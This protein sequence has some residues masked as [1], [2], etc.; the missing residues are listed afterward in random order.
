MASKNYTALY[1]HLVWCTKRR[2]PVLA[3]TWRK[4]LFFHIKAEG[5][6]KGYHVD[7]VNGISDHVH[8]LVGL[9]PT[10][11]VSKLAKDLKGEASRW[12]NERDLTDLRFEWARGYAAFTVSPKDVAMIRRYILNQ[13]QHHGDFSTYAGWEIP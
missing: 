4:T 5:I 7:T 3:P 1:V 8:A 2:Q 10:Q 9:K 13:E 12:I 6:Q 11:T